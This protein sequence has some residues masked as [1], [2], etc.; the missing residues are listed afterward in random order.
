M[1]RFNEGLFYI[2]CVYV[3]CV[4]SYVSVF[5]ELSED[6]LNVFCLLCLMSEKSSLIKTVMNLAIMQ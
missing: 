2:I 4:Y 6:L 3:S 1:L 5:I